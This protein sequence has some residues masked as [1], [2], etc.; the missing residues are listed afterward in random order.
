MFVWSLHT[1]IEQLAI[2][3]PE[4]AAFVSELRRSKDIAATVAAQFP[5]LTPISID[6]ALME[7]AARVLNIEATFDWDDV[8]SWV[9]IAKYLDDCGNENRFNHAVSEI[10]SRNNIVFSSTTGTHIALLGVEDLIIVQTGD[11]LLIANRSQADAIK[12]LSEILPEALL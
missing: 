2:H 4:L 1:V 7:N 11:S 10:S 5:K 6:Y 8:G 9:S 12:K 3:A